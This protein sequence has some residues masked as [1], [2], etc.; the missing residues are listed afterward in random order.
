MNENMSPEGME[1][2]QAYMAQQKMAWHEHE[3][4]YY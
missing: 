3:F 4:H 1:M 2:K